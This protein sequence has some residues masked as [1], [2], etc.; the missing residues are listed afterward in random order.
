MAQDI[1]DVIIHDKFVLIG[2]V[3]LFVVTNMSLTENFKLPEIGKGDKRSQWLGKVEDSVSIDGA[4]IGPDRFFYKAA[5]EAM[6]DLSIILN[7][8]V[9]IPGLGGI[10]LVSGLT[11]LSDMQITSLVFTQTNQDFGAITVK[12]TMK[13]C[14]KGFVAEVIGQGLNMASSLVGSA[15]NIATGKRSIG[16]PLG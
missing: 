14:P 4:L 12:I 10:P 15:A 11:V 6:A 7:A 2:A 1:S 9:S 8:L 16:G 13:H 5:L 3:P